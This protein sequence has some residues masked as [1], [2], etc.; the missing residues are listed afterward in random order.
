MNHGGHRYPR[1]P[2]PEFAKFNE[3]S[4]ATG[5]KNIKKRLIQRVPLEQTKSVAVLAKFDS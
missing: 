3:R 4:G 1:V 2:D 5:L